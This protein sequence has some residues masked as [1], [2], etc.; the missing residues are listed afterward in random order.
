MVDDNTAVRDA[1]ASLHDAFISYSRRDKEFA[2]RLGAALRAYKPPKGLGLEPR[3]LDI[4]RDQEDFTGVEY[5]E[6]VRRHL[7][8]SSRLVLICS[9]NARKS[10]YVNDEIRQ[11]VALRGADSIVPVL[12]CG[13]ANNEARDDQ[14]D[15]KAFPEALCAALRMPLAIDYRGFDPAGKQ[16]VNKDAFHAAWCSL[17]ANLYGLSRSEVEQREKKRETRRRR[18]TQSIVGG[19]MATLLAATAI[20][21]TFWRQAVEQR[22]AAVA[23]QLTAQA[24]LARNEAPKLIERSVLL[25]VESLKRLPTLEAEIVLRPQLAKMLLP[26][27]RISMGGQSGAYVFSADRT[28]VAAATAE[29]VKVYDLLTG[30]RVAVLDPLPPMMEFK[31]SPDGKHFA[32][33]SGS[34][35]PRLPRNYVAQVWRLQDAKEIAHLRYAEPVHMLAFNVDGRYLATSADKVARVWEV[36]S[37]RK[38]QAFELDA[39]ILDLAVSPDGGRLFTQTNR[40]VNQVRDVGSGKVLEDVKLSAGQENIALSPDWRHVATASEDSIRIAEL[41][42]GAEV[43]RILEPNTTA[44]AF[45]ED[46]EWLMASRRAIP[47]P[48]LT[49]EERAAD[50]SMILWDAHDFDELF[51]VR[52]VGSRDRLV[53][54]PDRE[55]VATLGAA[56]VVQIW[57]DTDREVSRLDGSGV[58]AIG[59][60]A[61]GKLVTGNWAGSVQ[62]WETTQGRE[63]G[64]L[65]HGGPVQSMAYTPDGKHLLTN[66]SDR[67][68]RVWDSAAS[69]EV[70]RIE[71]D[72]D[73]HVALDPDGKRFVGFLGDAMHVFDLGTKE[74]TRS[75]MPSG[76][77]GSVFTR[78]GKYLATAGLDNN[79]RLWAMPEAREIA[80]WPLGDGI[81]SLAFSPDGKLLVA[82]TI[83]SDVAIVWDRATR[84]VVAPFKEEGGYR[85]LTFSPDGRYLAA[86]VSA[87]YSGASPIPV[88]DGAVVLWNTSTWKEVHRL[89]QASGILG[90]SA[91]SKL[92][93]TNEDKLLVTSDAGYTQEFNARIWKVA[94]GKEIRQLLQHPAGVTAGAFTADGARLVTASADGA[95]LWDLL[96]GREMFLQR[97]ASTLIAVSPDGKYLATADDQG[98]VHTWFLRPDDLIDEACRRL[99]RNLTEDEWREFV[100]DGPYAPTCTNLK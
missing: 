88:A 48:Q 26:A 63:A 1:A 96:T 65:P 33:G 52:G 71:T 6:A 53:I 38:P 41:D 58:L 92:L 15:E 30:D 2:S 59:Y 36:G 94:T 34:M 17:L 27:R 99:T 31:F 76:T 73:G 21:I 10:E 79:V 50:H 32:T 42:G 11:F 55:Y 83:N 40:Q 25:A 46:G 80:H 67:S 64:R 98:V 5:H 39:F 93:A 9:P 45:T 66:S 61:D 89:R 37:E 54:S 85:Q 97:D 74:I 62:L 28:R 75:Q 87:R 44:P 47:D 51:R 95:R 100:A 24:E 23:R 20:S 19:I 60:A 57:S 8:A 13:L 43:K 22:R 78:D 81:A 86:S 56:Q 68:V 82:S 35:D 91:D 4:F 7:R 70:T 18:I 12:F 72:Q 14:E 84:D 29:G 69:R 3:H 77:G 16:K 90:F 49:D